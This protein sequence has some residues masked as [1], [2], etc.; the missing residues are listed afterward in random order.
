[1]EVSR[2]QKLQQL[3]RRGCMVPLVKLEAEQGR[4]ELIWGGDGRGSEITVKLK[5]DA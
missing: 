5:R 2:L 1:M 4:S 3:A